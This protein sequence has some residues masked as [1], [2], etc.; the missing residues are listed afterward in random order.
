MVGG[1]RPVIRTSH[2]A[3]RRSSVAVSTGLSPDQTHNLSL[4]SENYGR[5]GADGRRA[6]F[7]S[8]RPSFGFDGKGPPSPLASPR[9]GSYTPPSFPINGG[10]SPV[11]RKS[12]FKD[13][14]P[15]PLKRFDTFNMELKNSRIVFTL[16]VA[17]G[18]CLLVAVLSYVIRI[19]L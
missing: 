8:R 15:P 11:R 12:G 3:R 19:Y 1:M 16:V 4:L 6:S 13:G 2:E 9:R 10:P 7:E 14:K 18:C 5:P 17:F